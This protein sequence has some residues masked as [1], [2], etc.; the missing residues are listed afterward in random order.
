M[1][2]VAGLLT[3]VLVL[4][5][6]VVPAGSQGFKLQRA[7]IHITS[8]TTTT[9]VAG[10]AGRQIEIRD[11]FLRVDNGGVATTVTF[12]DSAGTNLLGTGVTFVLGTD[13]SLDWPLRPLPIG[14]LALTGAGNGFQIVTVGA[15]P[16][17]GVVLF[18]Q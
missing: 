8:A 7:P 9:V 17:N 13:Q 4:L 18:A 11:L 5:A 15:G 6:A 16:V 10:V 3:L 2:R 1:R 14:R 12:Q